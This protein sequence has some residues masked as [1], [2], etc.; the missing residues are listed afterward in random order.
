MFVSFIFKYFQVNN[1]LVNMEDNNM[2]EEGNDLIENIEEN[3][4]E[5]EGIVGQGNIKN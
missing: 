3:I 1:L 5:V 4:N 2:D